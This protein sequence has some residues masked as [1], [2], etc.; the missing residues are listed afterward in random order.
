MLFAYIASFMTYHRVCTQI[1]TTGATSRAGTT[2]HSGAL[3]FTPGFLCGVRVSRSFSFMC[4]FCRSLFVLFL[5][6]IG[7]SVF[8]FTDSDCLFGI[9]K[10][11]LFMSIKLLF[12]QINVL[13][14]I[15]Q[16]HNLKTKLTFTSTPV[17]TTDTFTFV[18]PV[19]IQDTLSL[20]TARVWTARIFCKQQMCK[21]HRLTVKYILRCIGYVNSIIT[22]GSQSAL[23][24]CFSSE[25]SGMFCVFCS[26]SIYGF[27]LPFG[28]FNC[29]TCFVQVLL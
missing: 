17:V 15:V 8:R 3:E 11:F 9:F 12:I 4:M 14:Q 2:Y 23:F 18:S 10:L 21:L 19:S 29:F 1:N 27:C 13:L 6:A 26:T 28:I 7:L 16:F 22:H 5:L 20:I 25:F 24:I